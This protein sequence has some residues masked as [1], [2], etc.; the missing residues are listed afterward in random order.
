MWLTTR[1]IIACCATLIYLS[2]GLWLLL[3]NKQYFEVPVFQQKIAGGVLILFAIYKGVKIYRSRM[4]HKRAVKIN[5]ENEN[6]H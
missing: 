2:V 1:N 3:V 6:G 4:R 5:R